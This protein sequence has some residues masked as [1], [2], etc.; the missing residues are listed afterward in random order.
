MYYKNITASFIIT[1]IVMEF[2]YF[3]ISERLRNKIQAT[4]N[5]GRRTQQKE[6]IRF[7]VISLGDMTTIEMW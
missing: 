4:I 1:L 6:V 3:Y 2:L 7:A 5:I